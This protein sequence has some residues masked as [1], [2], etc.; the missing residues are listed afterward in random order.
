MTFF[1]GF[2]A[3]L[4]ITIAIYTIF[5][6]ADHGWNLIPVF[7]G[8]ILAV[9]WR[10]QFNLDFLTFLMLT[11]VWIAWRGGFSAGALVLGAV[12]PLFGMP[13]LSAYLLFLTARTGGD[14]RQVLLGVHADPKT[15]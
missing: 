14:I 3:A 15:S 4:F 6:V 10:G 13:F 2:L 12:A 7:V 9:T 1:R 11:G 8:D 5:V